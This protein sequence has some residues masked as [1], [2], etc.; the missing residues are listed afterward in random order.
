MVWATSILTVKSTTRNFHRL[1]GLV[2]GFAE[3]SVKQKRVILDNWV[4]V[5][6]YC[7]RCRS[8]CPCAGHSK[9]NGRS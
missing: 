4:K 1:S 6:M 5:F 8:I 9:L 3:V 7:G 2:Y